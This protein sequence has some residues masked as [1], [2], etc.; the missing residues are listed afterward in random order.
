MSNHVGMIVV[1]VH[2]IPGRSGIKTIIPAFLAAMLAFFAVCGVCFPAA[3]ADSAG[4]LDAIMSDPSHSNKADPDYSVV[5]PADQVNQITITIPA[6][7]WQLMLANMTEMYGEFG[8]S[9]GGNAAGGQQAPG[10]GKGMPGASDS[11]DPVYVSADVSFEGLVWEHVGI[12]FKGFNSL[13]GSWN[14]GSYKIALKLNFDKYEDNYPELKNQ[15]FYGF[16]ELNLQ[17]AYNDDSL[18][19]DM[20]VPSIFRESGVAAPMT[21][22]YRVYVD[23]GEGPVYF[24]LYTMIES[25]EDTVIETQFSDDSGNLYKPEGD[26]ATFAAGTFDIDCFE[27]QTNEKEADWSDV[28]KLYTVL[29]ADTRLSDPEQWRSDL[30]EVFDVDTFLR[31]LAT[32]TVIQNWDTYGGNCRNF[33]LYT[34]PADGKITWIPWDNNYALN[35]GMDNGNTAPANPG[36]FPGNRTPGWQDPPGVT[37]AGDTVQTITGIAGTTTTVGQGSNSIP[38]HLLSFSDKDTIVTV[39]GSGTTTRPS[40]SSFT[41]S[42]VTGTQEG[43]STVSNVLSIEGIAGND[44]MPAFPGPGNQ[45]PGGMGAGGGMGR[46]ISLGLDDVGEN[47]P[48]IRYIADDPVYYATYQQ[49]LGM[50]VTTSFEPTAMEETY[51]YY[52]ALIEP[53]VTGPEGEVAEHT[54]LDSPE[55]FDTALD[56]LVSH[57]HDRYDAVMEFLSSA[58][59]P[60][61]VP[62]ATPTTTPSPAATSAISA[63]RGSA[64]PAVTITSPARSA[65]LTPG[66]A[67]DIAWTATYTGEIECVTLEYS[68]NGRTWTVISDDL[69]GEGTYEWTVPEGSGSLLMIRV[70]A[71]GTDGNTGSAGITCLVSSKGSGLSSLEDIRSGSASSST[72]SRDDILAS[73]GITQ[74]QSGDSHDVSYGESTSDNSFRAALLARL[75]VSQP[76]SLGQWRASHLSSASD[77]SGTTAP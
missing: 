62:T 17:G 37:G 7:N 34:D 3:A 38:A 23:Y 13:M 6:E 55:D 44:T 50:V 59:T 26:G 53:Y 33:Y 56:E 74:S 47:W 30:E 60:T 43:F 32:N 20:I 72:S 29:N 70:T 41:G 64:S 75:G 61:P 40:I 27:K 73:R 68:G 77:G 66:T 52:H 71:T 24:G 5:F 8:G 35:G 9:A 49:Y 58:I 2:R 51:R 10:Q 69:P 18:M 25:V 16:D 12:R 63:L 31:W 36:D 67:L 28:E 46:T 21:A 11:T 15:R 1:P 39:G 4:T 19:R 54:H 48:L 57:V 45:S 76:D 22:F 14:E 42:S 65:T